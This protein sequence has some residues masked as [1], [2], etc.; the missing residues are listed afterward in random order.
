M[1][2]A[3][4]R[5]L[6]FYTKREMLLHELRLYDPPLSL[7]FIEVG[8]STGRLSEWLVFH[9]PLCSKLESCHIFPSKGLEVKGVAPWI[10]EPG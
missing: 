5:V 3:F 6:V 9:P 10:S 8:L 7:I 2:S 4:I 1:F